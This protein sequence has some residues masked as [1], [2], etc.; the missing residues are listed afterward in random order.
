M[1]ATGIGEIS[2]QF[3]VKMNGAT[4]AVRHSAALTLCLVFR[5]ALG[6]HPQDLPVMSIGIVKTPAIHEA[7]VLWVHGPLSTAR[8]RLVDHLVHLRAARTGEREQT[9]GLRTR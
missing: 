7:V 2:F 8:H 5:H 1:Y 6:V 3:T 9:F 4:Q